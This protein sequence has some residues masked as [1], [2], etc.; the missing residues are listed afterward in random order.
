MQENT[1]KNSQTYMEA[2][3]I[4][5]YYR[6]LENR[7]AHETIVE[8]LREL[9]KVHG[10]ISPDTREL[11]AE[12]A[13]VKPSTIQAIVKR[14]PSLKTAACQKEVVICVGRSC[15]AKGNLE[16]LNKM[17]KSLKT[18]AEGISADSRVCLKT[19]ACLKHCRT[20]PNMLVNQCLCRAEQL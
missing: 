16:L 8:M 7:E 15:A 6:G 19:R 12:A 4:L 13:G 18:N 9:Q 3:E 5:D 2:R 10:F 17:R 11:A 14:I 20:A 1:D